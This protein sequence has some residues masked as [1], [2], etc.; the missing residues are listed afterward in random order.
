MR[1]R[2]ILAA[3]TIVMMLFTMIPVTAS[4]AKQQPAGEEFLEL[5]ETSYKEYVKDRS[6][7]CD[8]VW[9]EIQQV[10]MEGRQCYA[11]MENEDEYL[12]VPDYEAILQNLGKL[13]WVKNREELKD[14]KKRYI[15]EI[16]EEYKRH[17]KADY[18]EY[19]WDLIQDGLYVGKKAVN[20][21]ETFRDA[22]EGYSE[23]MTAMEWATT[24]EDLKDYQQEYIDSLSMV[25]NLC[26]DPNN[27]S[28]PVWEQI[29][30][31]YDEAIAAIKKT[32]LEYELEDI[33][34]DYLEEICS[35]S[36]MTYP[37]PY[38]ALEDALKELMKPVLD[39]F[40]DM[41]EA[42]YTLE[43]IEE[44]EEIIWDLETDLM[45]M[46][47][48]EDAEKLVNKALEKMKALPG[49][50]HDETFY[51]NYI[52][53][54]QTKGASGTSVRV[55]WNAS[56]ELNGYIVYRASSR[57]GTYKK[58]WTTYS[59]TRNY[60]VDK[61]L[62]YGKNYYYK[63]KGV[64]DIDWS[65]K[66]TKL[67]KPV[68]GTPK[69]TAPAMKLSKAG[70]V[71]VLLKWGKVTGADGYQIYRSTSVNG[72]FKLVKTVKK[73]STVQ[74]KDTSTKKGKKYCYKMRS[75]DVKKDGTK[76]YSSYSTIKTI[77]R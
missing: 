32:E 34:K 20:S 70:V 55:S 17:N 14:V 28:E 24:K 41:D 44:A 23:A 25:V 49:R 10:Y 5:L 46:K 16:D 43:R 48:R 74:W 27:F 60:Y 45:E 61:K 71:H 19:S 36:G 77:K 66:Y 18:S 72:Q 6:K 39:F 47:K 54:V 63:V 56:E 38:T 29:Q 76:K 11:D 40:E 57:N 68:K 67:S 2:T 69:L 15:K 22:A 7:Y 31:L 58:V 3:L 73:G 21:A 42:D 52:I 30:N 50:E 64:K 35:I 4:A 9:N 13:T 59:G 8:D 26:I 12:G 33:A 1:K 53:K 37:I 62:T 75:Y 65:E 51:K